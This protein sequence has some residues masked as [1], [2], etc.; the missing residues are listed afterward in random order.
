MSRL[1]IEVDTRTQQAE[2]DLNRLASRLDALEAAQ[3]DVG[4]ESREMGRAI[5]DSGRS[6]AQA[7]G[8]FGALS[9]TVSG[10]G[11]SIGGVA[12]AAT[13]AAG[14][15]IAMTHATAA[16]AGEQKRAAENAS[17]TIE[18]FNK[19][20]FA[21][22]R[23]GM[24]AETLGDSL[25]DVKEK[26]GDFLTAGGGGMQD[27]ADAIAM[28]AEEAR[29]FAKSMIG[30]GGQEIL[31]TMTNKMQEHGAS[32][33]QVSFA[34]EGM[35]SDLTKLIPLFT[36]NGKE[37]DRLARAFS[38]VASP[39]TDEDAETFSKFSEQAGLAGES[40]K[41]L[42]EKALAPIAEWMGEIYEKTAKVFALFNGDSV[43]GNAADLA[44]AR[45]ELARYSHEASILQTH[46]DK[47]KGKGGFLSFM[48]EMDAK[49]LEEAKARA[50]EYS[51]IVAKLEEKHRRLTGTQLAG[52][53]G[54]TKE[55]K[56]GGT[57]E[58]EGAD[59]ARKERAKEL[60]ELQKLYMS[61]SE[62]IKEAEKARLLELKT[63]LEKGDLNQV[64]HDKGVILAAETRAEALAALDKKETSSKVK[65]FDIR[66]ALLE[67]EQEA[68]IKS[69]STQEQQ[70][71]D[72]HTKALD[73]LS[74]NLEAQALLIAKHE[75]D[76]AA[77]RAQEAG[78]KVIA[79]DYD[80]EKERASFDEMQ[81]N[82]FFSPILTKEKHDE[83]LENLSS[84]FEQKNEIL[85]EQNAL[86]VEALA[87]EAEVMLAA[88]TGTEE[89]RQELIEQFT[90]K[91][92]ASENKYKD[93]VQANARTISTL[94]KNLSKQRLDE[95]QK[96]T[97]TAASLNAAFFDDNKS[98]KAGLVVIDTAA[99]VMN[100]YSTMDPI[101]A[102]AAAAG[103]IAVGATQLQAIKS[104]SKDGGGS[105][106]SSSS[107]AA[108]TPAQP[109][110]Q[111]PTMAVGVTDASGT[112]F[113]SNEV[114]VSFDESSDLGEFL[115][116]VIKKSQLAGR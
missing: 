44:E 7:G 14:A 110:Q 78:S 92:I 19:L 80:I 102:T 15:I 10:A 95:V 105:I 13:A 111:A 106:A 26:I 73:N 42:S 51:Q 98:I 84:L 46:V 31:Q 1:L 93:A 113:A 83:Y 81:E 88:F 101:S 91:R 109:E 54:F 25:R 35:A 33:E 9:S 58:S 87:L 5:G 67:R 66:A 116:R 47:N 86:E 45:E 70:L 6:A 108:P 63:A 41:A 27:F 8:S 71:A 3:R 37:A 40:F 64:Q 97:S 55:K 2:R 115:N 107:A 24:D 68:L 50:A 30:M 32:V 36:E 56:T 89:Q 49:A 28:S 79:I 29:D 12:T 62:L 60:K 103:I 85:A 74:G 18:E 61:K 100:A 65:E 48:Y 20:A 17:M 16:A 53:A 11:V 21:A 43:T 22:Q 69:L 23:Y 57:A 77:L 4:Q 90:A 94:E 34:L 82:S 75:A 52:E 76:V 99:G 114:R 59:K 112:G 39:I 72:S 104:A 38:D 96:I